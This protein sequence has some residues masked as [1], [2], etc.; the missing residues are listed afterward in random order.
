MRDA[1]K[2][3]RCIQ[4]R[5][6]SVG[7]GFVGYGVMSCPRSARAAAVIRRECVALV[8]MAVTT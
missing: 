7:M 8:E 6:V 1:L 4:V 3:E 5:R 2:N